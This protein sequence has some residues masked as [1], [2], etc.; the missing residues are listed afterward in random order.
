MGKKAVGLVSLGLLTAA[1]V[2]A[3][4]TPAFGQAKTGKIAFL[5]P[6]ATCADRF[7]NQDK[8]FFVK[9]VH[10]IDPSIE[11]IANNAQG[12]SSTQITQAEAALT[13]GA[14][15]L[16]VSPL[17]EAAGA[18]IIAKANAAHASVISYDGLATGAKPDFFISFQNEKVGELQASFLA[19]RL[20]KGATIIMI[21]GS[22]DI[23]PGRE[24]K[25]GAH[26][27][28]DPLFA[29]GKFKLGFEADTQGFVP[30]R[31]QAETEQALTTLND[32]V[33]AVLVANDGMASAVI[34]ALSARHLNGKVLVTGQDATDSGLQRILI[35]DQSMT[36]Y[37]AIKTEA[38]TAAQVAVNL[39]KGNKAAANKLAKTTVDNGTAQIPAVLLTPVVVTRSNL[40][41]TVIADGFTTRE[42]VCVGAAA[43]KCR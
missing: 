7:E 42:K 34:A 39:V 14:T 19:S 38:T 4:A 37:K 41:K 32:K 16:V 15:V 3:A 13:N 24:F 26:K 22:Q 33:D 6:C 27:I 43:A 36:V 30:A 1:L 35:G 17:D 31:A 28:L 8:P 23:A 25:A 9:A 21:N 2:A 12:S 40:F 18:A 29:S 20:R 11:V 10:D 5:M